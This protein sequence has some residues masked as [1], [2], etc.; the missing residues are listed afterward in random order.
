MAGEVSTCGMS[1][2]V[3][4]PVAADS[5]IVAALRAAGAIPFVKGNIPQSLMVPESDNAVFGQACNPFNPERTPGGSSGGDA[6][7]IAARCAPFGIGTDI[8][9]SIRIPAHF[10]GIYGFKATPGR[11]SRHGNSIPRL[12]NR[13]G[14]EKVLSVA[15]PMARSV[16]DLMAVM[17]V[18]WGR[19]C[20]GS[21]PAFT[22]VHDA[23]PTVPPMPLQRS[24]ITDSRPV[25]IGVIDTDGFFEPCLTQKRAVGEASA[26][27]KAAGHKLVKFKVPDPTLFVRAYVAIMSADGGMR[28]QVEG[29]E[30]EDVL[31]MYASLK[32]MAGLPA[33]LRPLLVR[34][35]LP[36]ARVRCRALQEVMAL[37]AASVRW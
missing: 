7:L 26:V 18:W 24:I 5:P 23:D 27:L 25:W 2:R 15:G 17:E 12:D 14:Q 10:C 1:V 20:H 6:G 19:P 16:D 4:L 33:I 11:M 31:P 36:G 30:G 37:V 9:G 35:C 22:S 34:G 21:A 13:S 32:R 3:G 28:Q 29:L 8:G